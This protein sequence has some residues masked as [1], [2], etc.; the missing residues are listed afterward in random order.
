MNQVQNLKNKTQEEVINT[1]KKIGIK[2]K[3]QKTI[4]NLTGN[5]EKAMEVYQSSKKNNKQTN[6]Q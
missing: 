5:Y 4:W 2:S 1:Y 3:L 6:E